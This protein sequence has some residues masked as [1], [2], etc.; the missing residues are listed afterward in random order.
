M[1]QILFSNR[2]KCNKEVPVFK[3]QKSNLR[4]EGKPLQYPES[5][6][7]RSKTFQVKYQGKLSLVM[8]L[9]LNSFQNK[10]IYYAIDD[11][12]YQFELETAECETLLA[13]LYSPIISLQ[14]NQF[15]NFFDIWV[16]EIYL[17]EVSKA[18]QFFS[19]TYQQTSYITIKFIYKTR[20][21]VKKQ[22]SLW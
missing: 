22:D 1:N 4:S 15:V 11:I 18:N 2:C 21:P 17:K 6:E 7:I 14:N 13:I 9:I 8:K 3:K 16:G 12:L 20:I 10:Y 19:N 5:K